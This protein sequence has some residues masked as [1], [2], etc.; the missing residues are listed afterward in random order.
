MGLSRTIKCFLEM[1]KYVGV[2]FSNQTDETKEIYRQLKWNRMTQLGERGK[3]T[4]NNFV[5]C[6][7]IDFNRKI[8][9]N[10]YHLNSIIVIWYKMTLCENKN[11]SYKFCRTQCQSLAIQTRRGHWMY[12]DA[13]VNAT[14]TLNEIH[15]AH[16]DCF[17]NELTVCHVIF[18]SG[19]HFITMQQI[20]MANN[21][22]WT[23]TSTRP[24]FSLYTFIS[25][26]YSLSLDLSS[27]K[28]N[29]YAHFENILFISACVSNFAWCQSFL[30]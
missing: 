12:D 3:I 23:N 22:R 27:C 21:T 4:F 10:C 30:L 28:C 26:I 11:G 9:C 25:Q 8:Q 18:E 15:I 14:V 5:K 16:F 2:S 7:R 13:D 1:T 20:Q 29:S 19:T 6:D 17:M 24:P